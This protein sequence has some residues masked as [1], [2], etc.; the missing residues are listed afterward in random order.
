VPLPPD[1]HDAFGDRS[2]VLP[3]FASVGWPI[4]SIGGPASRC[5]W[6]ERL[7]IGVG[8][9]TGGTVRGTLVA[10]R[11]TTSSVLADVLVM[12]RVMREV[13]RV[14]G[15]AQLG[16]RVNGI[17]EVRGSIPLASTPC[18]WDAVPVVSC[19]R[20]VYWQRVLWQA[21]ISRRRARAVSSV[22]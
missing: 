1:K 14:G 9:I 21:G 7:L 13:W 18:F 4:L 17:H 22:G 8:G 20:A 16:E 10:A 2:Q 6:Y 3:E 15:V 5:R 11:E 19:T 12:W